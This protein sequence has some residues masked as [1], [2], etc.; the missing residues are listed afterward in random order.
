[1]DAD[2]GKEGE[3][4]YVRGREEIERGNYWVTFLGLVRVEGYTEG[5]VGQD[6]E[7]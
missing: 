2:E 6:D 4:T 3:E 1:M 5:L 7:A